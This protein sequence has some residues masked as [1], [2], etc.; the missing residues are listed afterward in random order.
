M[1]CFHPLTAFRSLERNPSGKYGL[2]FNP[3]K[4]LIEGSGLKLPCGQCRGCRADKAKAMSIRCMH[5]AKMHDLNSFVTL[6]YSDEHLPVDYSVDERHFQDFVQRL[7]NARRGE[8]VRY[9]GV[10]EYGETTLRPH[11]HALLFGVHFGDRKQVAV[12]NDNRVYRSDELEEL[13]GLGQAEI[14]SVSPQSAGYC[15]RYSMKKLTG[16]LAHEFYVRP[17]P[18]DGQLHRVKPERALM[19][20]RPGIGATWLDRFA[21][22]AF[23]SDFLI[24]DGRRVQVPPYYLRKLTEAGGAAPV[25]KAGQWL[26]GQHDFSTPIKRARKRS[27][28]KPAQKANRTPERLRV[29]EEVFASKLKRLVRP[30]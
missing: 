5:E 20:R 12:R 22:D 30:L 15:A 23:P 11:A 19:S 29:R 27:S 9:F 16:D 21:S 6:T 7:R 25:P 4:A 14:G 26:R 28:L 8:K 18:V 24:V 2:T 10:L 13:W 1:T 17:S 3:M